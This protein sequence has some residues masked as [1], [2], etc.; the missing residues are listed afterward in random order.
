MF[1]LERNEQAEEELVTQ[2]AEDNARR[3][4]LTRWK[5]KSLQWTGGLGLDCHQDL[6]LTAERGE[7]SV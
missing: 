6:S 1:K 4:C 2:K 3:E 5:G 7:V